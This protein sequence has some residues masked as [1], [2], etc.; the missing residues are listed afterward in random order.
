MLDLA[1]TAVSV[2]GSMNAVVGRDLQYGLP[3]NDFGA[4]AQPASLKVDLADA[5]NT[6]D[7]IQFTLTVSY[8]ATVWAG[9]LAHARRS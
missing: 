8:D 5:H 4:K 3:T 1:G 6:A 7:R 2:S 9:N